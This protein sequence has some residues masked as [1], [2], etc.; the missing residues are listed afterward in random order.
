MKAS[1][2]LG[3]LAFLAVV[4]IILVGIIVFAGLA[5]IVGEAILEPLTR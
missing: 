4:F 1:R 3:P 5:A 2:I